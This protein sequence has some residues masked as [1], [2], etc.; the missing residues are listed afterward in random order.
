MR[1]TK[2]KNVIP[3]YS[4]PSRTPHNLALHMIAIMQSSA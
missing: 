1:S 4:Q 2:L 3:E